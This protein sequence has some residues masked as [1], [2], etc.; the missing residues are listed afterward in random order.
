VAGEQVTQQVATPH[1]D[2]AG[3]P[4]KELGCKHCGSD[5]FYSAGAHR[6]SHTTHW[7]YVCDPDTYAGIKGVKLRSE[8]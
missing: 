3:A 6:W 7:D 2:P 1:R 8:K 5:I 4:V